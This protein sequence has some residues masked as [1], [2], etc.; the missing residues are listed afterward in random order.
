MEGFVADGGADAEGLG[1]G[2]FVGGD[3]AGSERA[4]SI[5]AFS[6]APLAAAGDFLPVAGTDIIGA[7]VAEDGLESVLFSSV[8]CAAGDDDSEF[9]LVVHLVAT[10]G[11]REFDRG[12]GV[13]DGGGIFEEEDG[14]FGDLRAGFLRMFAV[15]E[16]YAKDGGGFDGSEEA[17]DIG[18]FVCDSPVPE[19][20][21]RDFAVAGGFADSVVSESLGVLVANPF[22]GVCIG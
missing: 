18:L 4:K 11:A 20:R 2:D 10:E 1:V 8:F 15:V 5:E 21:A 7:G 22:H 9:A 3:E 17:G 12:V 14:V 19:W 6:T 16:A 13:L